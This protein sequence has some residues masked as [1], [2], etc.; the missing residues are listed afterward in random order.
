MPGKVAWRI[1]AKAA[2]ATLEGRS[3][4]EAR[5]IAANIAKLPALL[6][7]MTLVRG[8]GQRQTVFGPWFGAKKVYGGR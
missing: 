3:R 7:G 2:G 4:D 1:F 8:A 5:R 6:K